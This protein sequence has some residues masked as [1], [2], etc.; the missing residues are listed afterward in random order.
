MA[1]YADNRRRARP[2]Q[3]LLCWLGWRPLLVVSVAFIIGTALA[4]LLPH[5]PFVALVLAGLALLAGLGAWFARG[6]PADFCLILTAAATGAAWYTARLCPGPEDISRHAPVKPDF[7]IARVVRSSHS[8]RTTVCRAQEMSLAGSARPL[9]VGGLLALQSRGAGRLLVGDTVRVDRPVLRPWRE[10]SNPNQYS[11]ADNWQR[12]RVWCYARGDSVQVLDHGRRL[13]P[14]DWAAD[15]RSALDK[16]LRLTMPGE[17]SATYANL[18]AAMVYGSALT[19]LPPDL[20]E[21]YRRTGTIHVLVVSGS[22][23]SL[24]VLVLLALTGGR[25]RAVGLVQVL[26]IVPVALLYAV[27]CGSEPSIL[28][29]TALAVVSIGA[30]Y[31]ARPYDLATALAFVAA[32][33][34]F[35][36]P[37]DLFA[38]GFQLTFTAFVGAIAG[39]R[40]GYWGARQAEPT[41]LLK[42]A[43]GVTYV[44]AGSVGAWAMTMPVLAY[45]FGG[46]AVVGNLAN[47]AVVPLAA[48]CLIFGLPAAL[49]ALFHSLLATGPLW[50]CRLALD[51]SA[52]VNRW[53]AD[54]PLAYVESLRAGWVLVSA[55]YLAVVAAYLLVRRSGS[56]GRGAGLAGGLASVALLLALMATAPRQTATSVTWLDVGEGLATVIETPGR[57]FILFDAGSRDPDLRGA[58]AAREVILPYL[59]SRGCHRV[60]A[61]VITHADVDHFN[62]ARTVAERL[63]VGCLILPPRGE[64]REYEDLVKSLRGAGATLATARAR[65]SLDLG[66]NTVLRFLHPPAYVWDSEA[67][68][69]DNCLVAILEASGRRVLL[70]S[71]LEVHGQRELLAAAGPGALR[72]DVLQVPHHGRKSA[73][74]ESF[75]DAVAP[76]LAVI[77]CGPEY[78]GGAVDVR[79]AERLGAQRATVLLTS[80]A[81]AVTVHLEPARIRWRC[82]LP[83]GESQAL[84]PSK[85][86]QIQ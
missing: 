3:G 33:L 74:L 56:V 18:L 67:S 55:W 22:Q 43:H 81:G 13:A 6:F 72:A 44:I 41:M 38:P 35:A 31:S 39:A 30:L 85:N 23:V 53:C 54:L 80:R 62:A 25:R 37:A 4:D 82:Y 70:T 75:L 11:P 52:Q 46:A 71:D 15:I 45:H 20:T 29:A 86:R 47:V 1:Y 83:C 10:R 76:V 79:F 17:D 73:F 36:E 26:I 14:A 28:R 12:R 40:L 48:L 69:N 8:G 61:L 51:A 49:L 84:A 68:D 7:I 2:G 59:R 16:R 5:R 32:V 19:D 63:P 77:P 9:T 42:L 58:Q 27:L 78:L 60:S 65:A 24:L 57:Q 64:G 66:S 34:V 21:L 50:L